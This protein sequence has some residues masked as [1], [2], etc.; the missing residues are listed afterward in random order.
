ME[1]DRHF[2][3][4]KKVTLSRGKIT[5]DKVEYG[6]D[7]LVNIH[8]EIVVRYSWVDL[9]VVHL[10]DLEG[11]FLGKA[12]PKEA[13]NPLASKRDDAHDRAMVAEHNRRIAKLKK[14]TMREARRMDGE[15]ADQPG[16]AALPY[17]LDASALEGEFTALPEPHAS[18]D[19]SEEERAKL[20]AIYTNAVSDMAAGPKI[21]RP[22][23]FQSEFDKNDWL[24]ESS[25]EGYQLTADDMAFMAVYEASEEYQIS[26]GARYE[27]LKA[28]EH[29]WHSH[30]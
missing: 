24:F 6:S 12:F 16:F 8:C 26:T 4:S 22:P 25:R 19:L 21:E 29:Y 3:W 17:I 18:Y 1:L 10:Y 30:I 9:S 13:V 28:Q 5:L 20:D 14:E 23:F 15:M 7:S 2:L 11:D 27:Q